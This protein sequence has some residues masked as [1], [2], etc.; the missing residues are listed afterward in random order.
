MHLK[1]PNGNPCDPD[2]LPGTAGAASYPCAIEAGLVASSAE[3]DA[4]TGA[5]SI[6]PANDPNTPVVDVSIASRKECEEL[7][8]QLMWVLENWKES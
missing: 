8:E 6:Y 3:G 7:I 5:L 4:G 2:D 1:F